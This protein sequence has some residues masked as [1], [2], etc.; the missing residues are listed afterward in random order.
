MDFEL[1]DD[2]RE[3]QSFVR[4]FVR[5]ECPP[6]LVRAV[7]EGHDDG[8]GLWKTM[9]GL[10]WTGLTVPAGDGGMGSSTVELVI[11]LEELGYA[12]DPT[13][14][15]ATT[16][17]Y[18]ALLRECVDDPAQR[19]ALFGVVCK[20]G[21]GSVAFAAA[22]VHARPDGDSWRLHGSTRHVL[23]ADRADEL[24]VVA[25]TDEGLGVFLVPP[26]AV[27]ATRTPTFDGAL[28][29]ADLTLD[30]VPVA[31]ERSW[32]GPEAERAVARARHEA[33]TGLAAT[34]VGASRRILDLVVE[35][36]KNRRQFGV[37]IGSFQAV[38]HMAVDL[39]VAVERARALCHFAALTIAEDDERR[40]LAASMAKAS[41]GDC[42]RLAA[43]HGIQ[44]FGGLGYTW[45]NDLQIYV[46]RAKAGEL[47]L[48][49]SAEH[50]AHIARSVL[51]DQRHS[52][53]AA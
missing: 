26:G 25:G 33:L 48:G 45:E 29:V 12:A 53:V 30:G 11:T 6:S 50:R 46:R 19:Q 23:D 22:T 21:A 37:P 14:F 51:A 28:H 47:L 15:L 24:A 3:L 17:Q 27:A 4:D 39:Y 52:E 20:G 7:V 1:D 16:S 42:Q 10:D 35:H 34:T 8:D 38:K 49:G 36:V 13:P 44:L 31:P 43:R 2:Q 9:V 41:A 5:R 18:V 32:C 40:G